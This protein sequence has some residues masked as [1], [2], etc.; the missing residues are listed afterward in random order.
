MGP[1][2]LN[3]YSLV[4]ELEFEL[5]IDHG[6]L[7]FSRSKKV[8]NWINKGVPAASGQQGTPGTARHAL[9]AGWG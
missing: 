9:L 4:G 6:Q 7:V 8:G 3:D 5:E 2:R 1:E